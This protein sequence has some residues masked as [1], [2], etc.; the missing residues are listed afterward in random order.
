MKL[1]AALA[2]LIA[3]L[4][5][6][7][8]AAQRASDTKVDPRIIAASLDY[9]NGVQALGEV[10]EVR[11]ESLSFLTPVDARRLLVD[12]WENP[13]QTA[14]N[15]LG[16]LV[17]KGF[18]PLDAASWAI[19]VR[20]Q[21]SGYVSDSD[22]DEIDYD[23]LLQQMQSDTREAS[24]ERVKQGYPGIELVGWASK[25]FYDKATHKL[26][27]AK[28]L[29][30][31]GE[32]DDTLNYNLRVLGRQG[33]MELNFIAGM[34]QLGEIR[35]AIPRVMSEVDFKPGYRYQEFDSSVDQVAGYGLAALIAGGVLKK[36]GLFGVILGVL[37]AA[38]KFLVVG[39]MALVGG[40]VAFFRRRRAR[41]PL[42]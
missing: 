4:A 2:F 9:K 8:A 35:A 28:Q 31:Q 16:V 19:V 14:Q 42:S 17:P 5:S 33:T 27:W 40:I 21:K 20:Y 6:W 26:H 22:A 13:P 11:A 32:S 37:V 25:P 39:A 34:D 24:A 36:A 30:F 3:S 41:R 18:D 38:K 7:Q 12:L 1:I 23:E 29:R 15:I 10:A